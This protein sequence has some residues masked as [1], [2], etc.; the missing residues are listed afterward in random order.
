VICSDCGVKPAEEGRTTCFRCRVATVG[1]GWRGGAV[2][3][4]NGWNITKSEWLSQNIGSE[5]EKQLAK[6]TDIERV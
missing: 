2:V 4:R 3:G 5:S 1:Y 6:R